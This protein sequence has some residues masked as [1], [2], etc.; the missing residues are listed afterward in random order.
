MIFVARHGIG[1]VSATVAEGEFLRTV[2]PARALARTTTGAS[3]TTMRSLQAARCGRARARWALC[4]AGESRGDAAPGPHRACSGP[5][6]TGRV[7]DRHE[8]EKVASPLGI[9]GGES[10]SGEPPVHTAPSSGPARS[11]SLKPSPAHR[12]Q[13]RELDARRLVDAAAGR[14]GGPGGSRL[15]VRAVL[16]VAEVAVA[17]RRRRQGAREVEPTQPAVAGAGAAPGSEEGAVRV[18]LLDAVV[19]SVPD[20]DVPARV[21][22]H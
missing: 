22:R 6:P 11:R 17:A 10:R 8:G 19:P 21:G 1:M 2:E 12:Q 15:L 14:D 5:A 3:T 13:V 16:G 4:R 18:E 9:C 20:V 7:P